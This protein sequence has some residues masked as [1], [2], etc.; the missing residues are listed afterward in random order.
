MSPIT[1]HF[2]GQ[3]NVA[4]LR[5]VLDLFIFGNWNLES[6]I[7]SQPANQMYPVSC[8]SRFR[9]RIVGEIAGFPHDFE[10]KTQF[11]TTLTNDQAAHVCT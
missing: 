6:S 11:E 10:I 8:H 7:I 1:A 5:A 3:F 2:V 4:D 9:F